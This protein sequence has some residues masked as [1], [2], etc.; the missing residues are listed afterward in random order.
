M[1]TVTVAFGPINTP[2]AFC[3]NTR[4][5]AEAAQEKI[6][7]S[8]QYGHIADDFGQVA[9]FPDGSIHGVTVEDTAKTGEAHNL[10]MLSMARTQAKYDNMLMND[11]DPELKKVIQRLRTQEIQRR[12]AGNGFSMGPMPQN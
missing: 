5:A 10:R 12:F 11:P 4:E 8:N 3:F 6:L 9:V 2:W 7:S 1:F